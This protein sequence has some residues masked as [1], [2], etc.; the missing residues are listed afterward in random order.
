MQNLFLSELFQQLSTFKKFP[1]YQFERRIDAFIGFF[2]PAVL[3]ARYQHHADFTWPEFPVST[4]QTKKLASNIDYACIDKLKKSLALVELKTEKLSV[5]TEQIAYYLQAM[6]TSWE[7]HIKDVKWI[8]SGSQQAAKYDFLLEQME[9]VQ[10]LNTIFGI[11]LAPAEAS[12]KFWSAVESVAKAK[13]EDPEA[14][15]RIWRFLSLEDFASTNIDSEHSAS[16]DIV[17]E[18]LCEAI[19]NN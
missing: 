6:S 1:K 5:N 17:R 12:S 4:H 18:G 14:Y 19:A 7:Q 2:L 13:E 10:E 11:Y 9:S 3:E 8:A 16:W 15:R